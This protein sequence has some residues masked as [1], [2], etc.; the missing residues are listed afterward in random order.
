M[1]LF[2]N[3][4]TDGSRKQDLLVLSH[5]GGHVRVA[6][7]SLL[8]ELSLAE[9]RVAR[10]LLRPPNPPTPRNEAS[11]AMTKERARG[12]PP[13]DGGVG[14]RERAC[15]SEDSTKRAFRARPAGHAPPPLARRR[16]ECAAARETSQ[17]TLARPSKPSSSRPLAPLV[18]TTEGALSLSSA[19]ARRARHRRARERATDHAHGRGR[20]VRALPGRREFA[21]RHLATADHRRVRRALR[22]HGEER[23]LVGD[24]RRRIEPRRRAAR[25]PRA[26]AVGRGGDPRQ[27]C[28][29][30]GLGAIAGAGLAPHRERLDRVAEALRVLRRELGRARADR[31]GTADEAEGWPHARLPDHGEV[32][33][34]ALPKKTNDGGWGR[35]GAEV[36]N[37]PKPQSETCTSLHM[38]TKHS[39]KHHRDE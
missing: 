5:F 37:S 9:A 24:R 3:P 2:M 32:W 1:Y 33:V 25:G 35:V 8:A 18:V 10:D 27:P 30:V 6:Q 7:H 26:R 11:R 21:R 16:A 28:L 15:V 34:F 19:L 38:T 14:K 20:G 4:C 39:T 13:N 17:A 31:E 29:V 12:A 22:R 36:S 23:R